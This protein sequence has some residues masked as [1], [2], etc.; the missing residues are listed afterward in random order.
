MH[1]KHFIFLALYKKFLFPFS[2]LIGLL[3]ASVH[4]SVTMRYFFNENIIA[5]IIE[6]FLAGKKEK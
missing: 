3:S 6:A 1:L 4:N 5:F 2:Y